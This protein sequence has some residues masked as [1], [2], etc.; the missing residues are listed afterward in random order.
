MCVKTCDCNHC[1]KVKTCTDC[2]H[3]KYITGK[4]NCNSEGIKGCQIRIPY[5]SERLSGNKVEE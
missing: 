3:C 4:V 1:Y 2:E 5:P